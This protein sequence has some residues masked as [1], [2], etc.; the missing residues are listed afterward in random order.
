MGIRYFFLCV[1]TDYLASKILVAVKVGSHARRSNYKRIIQNTVKKMW[2]NIIQALGS[3]SPA[4]RVANFVKSMIQKQILKQHCLDREDILILYWIM[5]SKQTHNNWISL[6]GQF[7]TEERAHGTIHM[8]F[9]QTPHEYLLHMYMFHHL[10][11]AI[12]RFHTK[13][14]AKQLNL[15][16]LIAGANSPSETQGQSVRLLTAPQSRSKRPGP[17]APPGDEGWLPLGL[18]GWS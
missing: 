15:F 5:I 11:I 2:M 12:Q 6:G 9:A 18:R 7:N 13:A 4:E 8:I 10:L 14:W 16:Y 3:S 17:R 1:A